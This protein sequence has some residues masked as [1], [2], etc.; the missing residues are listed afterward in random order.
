[1]VGDEGAVVDSGSNAAMLHL[2]SP[3]MRV[4]INRTTP[5]LRRDIEGVEQVFAVL[6]GQSLEIGK[7]HLHEVAFVVPMN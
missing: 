5:T 2:A 7:H 1:M 4:K 3:R 6:P